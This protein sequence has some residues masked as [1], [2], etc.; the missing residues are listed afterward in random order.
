MRSSRGRPAARRCGACRRGTCQVLAVD[1]QLAGDLR[2]VVLGHAAGCGRDGE[3]GRGGEDERAADHR[4]T[5]VSYPASFSVLTT[6]PACSFPR[7]SS[8]SS[9][10]VSRTWGSRPSRTCDTSTMLAPSPRSRRAARR[11]GRGGPRAGDDH[12]ATAD[13][14][15]VAAGDRGERPGSTLPPESTATVVP[16]SA[17]RTWPPSSAATPTAPAPSTT[18]SRAPSGR[19]SPPRCRPRR[20]RRLRPRA[21]SNPSVSSPGASP[22]CRRQSSSTRVGGTGSPRRSDSG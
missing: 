15:L 20:R 2:P 22:R 10:A 8:T 3:R 18:A 13:L 14:A 19:P 17:G 1:P 12:E 5:S 16:P 6:D 21:Q 7:V 11:G 4:R 9:T